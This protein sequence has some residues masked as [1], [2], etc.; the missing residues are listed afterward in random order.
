MAS[1]SDVLALLRRHGDRWCSGE[2]LSQ[3]LGISRAAIWKH[4][5]HLETEGYVIEAVPH[6]GYRLVGIPDRMLPDEIEFNL[7]TA[8]VGRT[9]Y[10][11]KATSSTNDRAI[12]LARSGAPEGSLVVAEVQSRGRGRRERVW[13]AEE[14][15]NLLFT[16]IFRPPWSVALAPRL[17][18]IV[19]VGLAE[20]IDIMTGLTVSVKWPNDLIINRK[21]AA[22]ILTEMQ[23]QADRVDYVVVGAGINVNGRIPKDTRYPATSLAAETGRSVDR[24]DLIKLMLQKI[25]HQYLAV[26]Q[27][28]MAAII[29]AWRQRALSIGAMAKIEQG[30]RQ[31]EGMVMGIDEQGCLLLR[32]AQGLIE[33]ISS[34]EMTGTG[35][36]SQK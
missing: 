21:K 15:K 34:G 6:S 20:A 24:L 27:E 35:R 19:A 11:F 17:T 3:H 8:L 32:T 23:G 16:L 2:D 13:E 28:G 7:N 9:I 10:A 1:T 25:E 31:V 18:Q 29:E 26:R 36:G 30:H 4:I 5:R 33:T 22:G 14:G 12:D